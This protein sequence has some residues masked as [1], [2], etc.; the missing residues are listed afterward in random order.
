MAISRRVRITRTAISPRLAIKILPNMHEELY[1]GTRIAEFR[2]A[3]IGEVSCSYY[4]PRFNRRIVKGTG[5][6]PHAPAADSARADRPDGRA[7]GRR[8]LV[9]NGQ[10]E[11]SETEPGNGVPDAQDAEIGRRGGLA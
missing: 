3:R 2:A 8:A 11:R 5:S 4:G 6:S 7:S 9:P 10:R 1:Q